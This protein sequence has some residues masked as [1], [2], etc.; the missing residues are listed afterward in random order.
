[1]SIAIA[2]KGS[3]GAHGQLWS[4]RADDWA[5]VQ[6][7]TA[8]PLYHAALERLE[9]GSDTRV[10]DV[11]CG[12]GLFAQMASQR[13]ASVSGVDAAPALTAIAGR[14]VPAGD[15]HVG[16]MEALPF[17]SGVFDVV[18]GFNAFQYAERPVRALAEAARVV[19]RGGSVFVATWGRAEDSEAMAYIAAVNSVLPPSPPGPGPFALSDPRALEAVAAETGLKL[20]PIVDVDVPFVY[21]SLEAALRGM[22]SAGPAVKAIDAAGEARVRA[23]VTDAIA[24]YRLS[25][26]GYRLENRFR[27]LVATRAI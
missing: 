17:D 11:G 24:P 21:P 7:A 3:A 4:Q 13:G 9:V 1:M 5:A 6:E 26:G 25:S 20:G 8:L 12:A 10:L 23:V 2:F 15:F 27:Y 14:R 19:R 22:L 16:E 18:T